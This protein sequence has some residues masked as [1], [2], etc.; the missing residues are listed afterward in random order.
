M[1]NTY[2]PMAVSFQCMTKFTTNKKR[3][4]ENQK[5]D[6][7]LHRN[8]KAKGK[9]NTKSKIFQMDKAEVERAR[10]HTSHLSERH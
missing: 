5:S 3:R 2:K 8:T 1:G 6:A 4:K 7:R 9:T 10:V